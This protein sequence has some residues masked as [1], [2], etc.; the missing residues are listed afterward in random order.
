MQRAP[1][2]GGTIEVMINPMLYNS[3]LGF[4]MCSEFCGPK[5]HE[6][7]APDLAQ[8]KAQGSAQGLLW[9]I[10]QTELALKG[11]LGTA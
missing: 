1:R 3:A 8:G 7:I 4:R 9:V 10:P 2:L 6:S 11:R 5:G